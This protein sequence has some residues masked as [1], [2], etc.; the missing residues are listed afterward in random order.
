MRKV[1]TAVAAV[2]AVAVMS[3]GAAACTPEQQTQ[4]GTTLGT[5]A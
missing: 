5:T 1:R 2:V 3:L 4:V